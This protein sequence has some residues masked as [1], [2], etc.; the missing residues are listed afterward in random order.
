MLVRS[1]CSCS[2]FTVTVD[3]SLELDTENVVCNTCGDIVTGISEFAKNG[4]KISGDVIKAPKRAFSFKC[5]SC[6]KYCQV[7]FLNHKAC[8]DKLT[9]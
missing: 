6:D 1:N 9:W 4:M 8:S 2:K 5:L 7:A 3:A